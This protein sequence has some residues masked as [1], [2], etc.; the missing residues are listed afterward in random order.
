[1]FPARARSCFLH[2]MTFNS[3][4]SEILAEVCQCVISL[5]NSAAHLQKCNSGN[6]HDAQVSLTYALG[7]VQRS[8]KSSQK[9]LLICMWMCMYLWECVCFTRPGRATGNA[10]ATLV[11]Q[12]AINPFIST[13]P[14]LLSASISPLTHRRSI[15]PTSH[16][17]SCWL[18][19][20]KCPHADYFEWI[21]SDWRC[22]MRCVNEVS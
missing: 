5:L 9:G 7:E 19:F 1:M 18:K 10:A 16:S 22:Q 4:Q 11:G 8:S 6:A 13:S 20:E 21:P 3:R 17:L 15:H 12:C 2:F 14:S